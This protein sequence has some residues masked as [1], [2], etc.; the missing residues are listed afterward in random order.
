MLW[1]RQ[2]HTP[3]PVMG[4]HMVAWLRTTT[5]LPTRTATAALMEGSKGTLR[6]S[7]R[8]PGRIW[9]ALE[10]I[11]KKRVRTKKVGRGPNECRIPKQRQ[12]CCHLSFRQ[13]LPAPVSPC[14]RTSGKKN[15]T[16]RLRRHLFSQPRL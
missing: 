9:E 1:W 4:V 16:T 8:L 7:P 3:D 6:I 12:E 2:S 10:G 13:Q 5:R 15:L 11:M 14:L